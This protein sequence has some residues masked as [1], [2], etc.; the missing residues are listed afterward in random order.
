MAIADACRLVS[1][2][3]L[4]MPGEVE[5]VV[6]GTG[7]AIRAYFDNGSKAYR[8]SADGALEDVTAGFPTWPPS[9]ALLKRGRCSTSAGYRR[10][11]L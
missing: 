7:W 9:R 1:D 3:E 10:T 6:L 5:F 4:R 8:V 11:S 2:H